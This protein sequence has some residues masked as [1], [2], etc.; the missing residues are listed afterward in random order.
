[1]ER[2][3]F[4]L[5]WEPVKLKFE[6]P[7]VEEIFAVP[8]EV[9]TVMVVVS[10]L[11]RPETTSLP[12]LRD[13]NVAPASTLTLVEVGVTATAARAGFAPITTS[14]DTRA[15]TKKPRSQRLRTITLLEGI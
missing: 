11:P 4:T 10:P 8:A 6:E 5:A 13:T 15:L 14:P 9:V 2:D 1:M 7:A 3:A 12:T